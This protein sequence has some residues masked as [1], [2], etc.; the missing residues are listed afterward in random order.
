MR[1]GD[2]AKKGQE[3]ILVGRKQG[4]EALIVSLE[5]ELE[6]ERANLE[7]MRNLAERDAIAQEKIDEA[8]AEFE[9]VRAQL[10]RARESL[11]DYAITAPWN[12]VISAVNVEEGQFVAPGTPLI[13]MYD[14]DSLVI[15]AS[16]PERNAAEISVGMK[17]ELSLDAF[18]E[19]QFPGLINRVYPYLD[20]RLR[21]R[22]VEIVPEEV[23]DLLPGMFARIKIVLEAADNAVVVPKEAVISTPEGPAVFVIKDG[24]AQRRMIKTG[25]EEEDRIQIAA[26]VLAG[27]KIAVEGHRDLK[28]GSKVRGNEGN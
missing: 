16:V 1:E 3:L 19:K 23:L 12:G 2:H 22:T 10:V 5:Q 28:P 24:T 6:K 7:R 25:I 18:P 4:T 27:E 13:E 20:P 8:M 11:R 26:G 9:K 21:T 17:T 15:M 14:P